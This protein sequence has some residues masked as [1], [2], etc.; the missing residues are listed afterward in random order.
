[1]CIDRGCRDHMIMYYGIY[2]DVR[3]PQAAG[4][5]VNQDFMAVSVTLQS[6]LRVAATE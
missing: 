1:M 6:V 4:Y 3:L 2:R 5:N